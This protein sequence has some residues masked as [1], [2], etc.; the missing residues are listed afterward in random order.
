MT[1]EPSRGASGR[2]CACGCGGTT[3]LATRTQRGVRKGEPNRYIFG[4][5]NKNRRLLEPVAKFWSLTVVGSPD[6]CWQWQGTLRNGYGHFT[7]GYSRIYAHR[8]SYEVHLGPIP[9]GLYVCHTCDNRKCVNPGHLFLGTQA[10]NMADMARKGRA[11]RGEKHH[12]SKLTTEQAR[13][14][15][16]RHAHEPV[17]ALAAR[18]SV[19]PATVRDV[20]HGRTWGWV[21]A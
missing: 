15:R 9:S 20:I 12:H 14:I 3:A 6:E 19:S 2:L 17:P 18:L 13:E 10:D 21:S 4:H 11:S 7:D 8:F 1:I 5:G 16:R